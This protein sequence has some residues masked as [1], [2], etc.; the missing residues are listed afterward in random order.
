MRFSS[1]R[2][3]DFQLEGFKGVCLATLPVNGLSVLSGQNSS[4]KSS[5]VQALLL[6]AQS[7]IETLNANGE[8][9]LLGAARELSNRE[10]PESSIY[11]RF[12]FPAKPLMNEARRLTFRPPSFRTERGHSWRQILDPSGISL[13]ETELEYSEDCFDAARLNLQRLLVHLEGDEATFATGDIEL[14]FAQSIDWLDLTSASEAVGEGRDGGGEDLDYEPNSYFYEVTTAEALQLRCFV[15]IEESRI[16]DAFCVVSVEDLRQILHP[17]S[18]G[19]AKGDA[20]CILSTLRSVVAGDS[21]AENRGGLRYRVASREDGLLNEVEKLVD[22][23]LGDCTEPA[24]RAVDCQIQEYLE[25]IVGE[26][27]NLIVPLM[28]GVATGLAA[29]FLPLVRAVAI[30]QAVIS[31]ISQVASKIRYIGPLRAAAKPAYGVELSSRTTPLGVTGGSTAAFLERVRAAAARASVWNDGRGDRSLNPQQILDGIEK[32]LV[33]IGVGERVESLARG[34]VG[35]ELQVED[36]RGT[37]NVTDLGTGVSQVLPILVL[38][39][40]S[41]PGSVVVIEQPEVHLHPAMQ[42]R[43]GDVLLRHSEDKALIVETHSDYLL[44]RLRLR[45][46]E[47]GVAKQD[48]ETFPKVTFLWSELAEDETGYVIGPLA[49]DQFGD[50]AQWPDGFFDSFENDVEGILRAKIRLAGGSNEAL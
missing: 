19:F 1:T 45:I 31:S 14:R 38:L 8:V 37:W 32:D 2:K 33:S 4:G 24:Y 20:D 42:S 17:P 28:G 26:S 43:I 18:G 29:D 10:D 48:R 36:A 47:S 30:V 7:R 50:L 40:S 11:F 49:L 13:V 39:N 9:V 21:F 41:P 35:Y 5:L 46:L 27:N 25:S 16:A 44:N 3:F 34:K 22:A 23:A 6:L 15:R 12:A